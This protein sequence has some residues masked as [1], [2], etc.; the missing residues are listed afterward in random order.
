MSKQVINATQREALWTAHNG[1]CAYTRQPLDGA[2]GV[3][4]ETQISAHQGVDT[5]K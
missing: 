5:R 2:V 4:G 3:A 1:R